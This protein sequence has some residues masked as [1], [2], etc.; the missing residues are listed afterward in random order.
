MIA[1][2][3]GAVIFVIAISTPLYSQSFDCRLATRADER[4]ICSNVV[5]AELDR[6]V[7]ALYALRG[8]NQAAIRDQRSW[9]ATR[10]RCNEDVGCLRKAYLDRI[11]ELAQNLP[12]SSSTV[13]NA[14]TY[15]YSCKVDGKT[16]PLR[17]N[18]G[19]NILEWRGSKFSISN[20]NDDPDNIVCA[21]AGW[22][23]EGNGTSFDFC[24][25]TQGYADFVKDGVQVQCD[26]Q[27]P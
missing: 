9:L 7:S 4:A 3:V 6:T 2:Y 17:V 8:K 10:T 12:Q 16:Y 5:L 24:T 13:S 21:K 15:N 23:V 26:L 25:A 18:A 1:R 14:E 11:N 19:A 27:R 20:A 22:H